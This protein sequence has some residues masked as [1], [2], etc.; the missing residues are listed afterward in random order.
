MVAPNGRL[1]VG[2]FAETNRTR[3]YMEWC[4]AWSLIHRTEKEMFDLAESAGI[5]LEMCCQE[6]DSLGAIRF[7]IANQA[8]SDRI[9]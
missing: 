7:L 4:G 5:P 2:A 3:P 1:I 8:D 9:G 6:V